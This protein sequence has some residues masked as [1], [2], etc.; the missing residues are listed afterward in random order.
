MASGGTGDVLTGI[1][2]ALLGQKFSF[3]DAARFGVFIH[4]L[5]GDL[6]AK[7]IGEV[8]LTAGDLLD[9]LPAAIRK[10]TAY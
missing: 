2:G 1:L 3:W 10:V 6:A 9:F 5:A 8:S 7:K 4:G